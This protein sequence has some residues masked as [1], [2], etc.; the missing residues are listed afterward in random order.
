MEAN[1]DN[2]KIAND[3]ATPVFL[4]AQEAKADKDKASIGGFTS[5]YVAVGEGHQEAVRLFE[6][7]ADKDEAK[8]DGPRKGSW[9]LCC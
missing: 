1:A 8:D 6:A 4:A 7:K 2:D 5:V 9:S 3:G